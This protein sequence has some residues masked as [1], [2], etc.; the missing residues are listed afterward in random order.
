M[1]EYLFIAFTWFMDNWLQALYY[2]LAISSSVVLTEGALKKVI[3]NKIN[4]KTL[5]KAVLSLLSIVLT[6]ISTA[7]VFLT[8]SMAWEYYALA[9]VALCVATVIVYWLYE[10]TGVRPLIE[11]VGTIFRD[12]V[13]SAI[14]KV[15]HRNTNP[16]NATAELKKELSAA[17]KT[18]TETV[19]ATLQN[20]VKEDDLSDL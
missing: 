14:R 9:S 4:I 2:T 20:F 17:V 10:N 3:V 8:D 6:F 1:K 5:R 18:S 12:K 7:I 19:Q 15:I 16:T 13:I 11:L